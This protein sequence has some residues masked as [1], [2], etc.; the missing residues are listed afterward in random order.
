MRSQSRESGQLP[1]K[2]EVTDPTP[3]SSSKDKRMFSDI[4]SDKP[5]DTKRDRIDENVLKNVPVADSSMCTH[6]ESA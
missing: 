6:T 2:G 5:S 3:S 1:N 4:R